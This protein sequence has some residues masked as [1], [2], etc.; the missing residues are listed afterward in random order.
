M[1]AFLHAIGTA[2]PENKIPQDK[3]LRFMQQAHELSEAE[4]KKLE[5]LYR[6][7]GIKY[8]YSILDDYQKTSGFTFY[9]ETLDPFPGTNSRQSK[10]QDHALELSVHA[11][12]KVVGNPAEITHVI[13][14]SCTGLYAPGLDIQL[15]ESLG[16]SHNVH[17]A[18]INFMGCYAAVNALKVA[19]AFCRTEKPANVLVVCTELC[20][21]HF[22]KESTDDNLLANAL[23]GDGSAAALVSNQPKSG[24]LE[25]SQFF[26]SIE[27]AGSNEMAWG[28][29]ATGF[30]MKLSSYVPDHLKNGVPKLLERMREEADLDNIDYYAFHPGGKRILQVLEE[31][32][33]LKPEENNFSREVLKHYGNMSSPT[34]LFVLSEI[35]AHRQQNP[36]GQKVLALAFGPGLTIE[37]MVLNFTTT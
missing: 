2:V 23:F 25:L 18:G 34:L 28:V 31:I 12:K 30:E 36:N 33:G 9:P 24:A 3:V 1:S 20:T 13:A 37:G 35:I 16:L 8:R 11:A 14:V 32:L 27:P 22:Q 10:F 4:S 5:V 19:E 26:T 17:R 29:G 7:T 15:V 6:A 21:L